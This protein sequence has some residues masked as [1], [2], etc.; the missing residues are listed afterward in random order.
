MSWYHDAACQ[1]EETE[2]FSPDRQLLSQDRSV[3]S[4]EISLETL[5]NRLEMDSLNRRSRQGVDRHGTAW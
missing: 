3:E 5:L 4:F 1:I 2:L